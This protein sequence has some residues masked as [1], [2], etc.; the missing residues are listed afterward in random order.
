[1]KFI[2]LISLVLANSIAYAN[3]STKA[4]EIAQAIYNNSNHW[5]SLS[6]SMTMFIRTKSGKT[7]QYQIE[8]IQ[9]KEDGGSNKKKLVFTQPQSIKGTSILSHAGDT[10]EKQWM[11]APKTNKVQRISG[12]HKSRSFAGSQYT[13]EDLSTFNPNNYYF[14]WVEETACEGD[15]CQVI[16]SYPETKGS[17]YSKL[18]SWVDTKNRVQ[19]IEYYDHGGELLKTLTVNTFE[20]LEGDF[21]WPMASTMLNHQNGK[22]TEL[23]INA[24]QENKT[25]TSSMFNEKSLRI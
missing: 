13:F 25:I 15:T 12:K 11:F 5:Q 17:Y 18:K 19:K 22:S 2:V 10:D 16:I 20:K 14:R 6:M 23:V 7:N 8:G 24:I 9:L 3:C 21:W 4:D 1:M